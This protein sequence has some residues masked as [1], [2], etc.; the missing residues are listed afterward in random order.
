MSERYLIVD[1][2]KFSYEGLF[3]V[4]ELYS[5][6][7]SWFFEKGWD[8]HE[9]MNEELITPEGKQIRIVLENWKS[10]TD[11]YKLQVKIKL[12]FINV[13][14]VDV[15]KENHTLKLDHGVFR[16]TIDGYVLTDRDQLWKNKPFMW[17]LSILSEKYFFNKHF[18]KLEK[19]IL[20]DMDD[21]Y[22]KI[23]N[24]LNVYKYNY[25]K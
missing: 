1:H 10:T 5:V 23:K 12:N 21:L 20:S 7:S 9:R 3:S 6:S 8:W 17:F 14:E 2:L 15:K 4:A 13:Q 22:D 24:Y 19:W 18:S 16:I 11:Y 25:R